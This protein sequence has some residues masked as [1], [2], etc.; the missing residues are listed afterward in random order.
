M[1]DQ[2]GLILIAHSERRT[3]IALYSWLDAEGYLVAPC[4]TREDL[5]RHCA[6]Y[7]PELVMTDD[8]SHDDQRGGLLRTLQER[9]PQATV[10]LLPELMGL[11]SL[12]DF[13]EFAWIKEILRRGEEYPVPP[14]PIPVCGS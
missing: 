11:E 9:A 14:S 13:L 10:V 12:G 4:F 8:S 1:R 7:K 3:L 5:L 2:E 6:Q